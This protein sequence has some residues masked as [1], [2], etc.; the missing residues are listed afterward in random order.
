M[1]ESTI[2]AYFGCW[3]Q[4]GHFLWDRH[5]HHFDRY[6]AD[7]KLIPDTKLLD[8]SVIFL[9]FREQVGDGCIT[10]LPGPN[11]TV[12]AWWGN[13]PWDKRG[14]VNSAVITNGELGESAMWSRFQRYFAALSGQLK[15]PRIVP[16]GY[17]I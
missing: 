10:Y 3:G 8:A 12:L 9:P 15:R 2:I 17:G 14:K 11:R 1:S 6:Q 4:P 16:P 5:G 7:K 13:N